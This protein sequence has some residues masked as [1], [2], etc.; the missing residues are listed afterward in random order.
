MPG[1]AAR[2]DY[3]INHH[4]SPSWTIIANALWYLKESEALKMV[5]KL[6]LKGETAVGVRTE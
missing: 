3:I 6:Y 2:A 1:N 4:P 5:Q